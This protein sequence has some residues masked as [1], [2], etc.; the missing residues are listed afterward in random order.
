MDISF[1]SL[2]R[3]SFNRKQTSSRCT[4][5]ITT[6]DLCVFSVLTASGES[7]SGI[8]VSSIE[9]IA[10]IK[11][12]L[13]SSCIAYS[14]GGFYIHAKTANS[15][16]CC[17]S[18]CKVDRQC[19]V[20]IPVMGTLGAAVSET[21][22]ITLYHPNNEGLNH[23]DAI[24]S[25]KPRCCFQNYSFNYISSD[26]LSCG[27][28]GAEFCPHNTLFGNPPDFVISFYKIA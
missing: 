9:N 15:Y 17:L 22:T 3:R 20:Y 26:I 27:R 8:F 25:I 10:F 13:F 28:D 16:R 23:V 2:L 6:I 21:N 19:H 1:C 7:G 11:N 14:Y 12:S 24:W 4:S 5:G 18:K